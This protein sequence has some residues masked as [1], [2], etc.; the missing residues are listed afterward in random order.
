VLGTKWGET[1]SKISAKTQSLSCKVFIAFGD[2]SPLAYDTMLI[3][4]LLLTFQRSL[5]PPH[6]GKLNKCKILAELVALHCTQS[7]SVLCLP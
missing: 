4:N 6:S 7:P 1:L 5:M 2:C 3:G